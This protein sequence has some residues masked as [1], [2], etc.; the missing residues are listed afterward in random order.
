MADVTLLNLNFPAN[1]RICGLYFEKFGRKHST[2]NIRVEE[3]LRFKDAAHVRNHLNYLFRCDKAQRWTNHSSKGN[4][5]IYFESN[6]NKGKIIFFDKTL[7]ELS[8]YAK[9]LRE[10]INKEKDFLKRGRM[11]RIELMDEAKRFNEANV[12]FGK[13][14]YEAMVV[15]DKISPI[16]VVGHQDQED[17]YLHW[18]LVYA[19]DSDQDFGQ[20]LA[21]GNR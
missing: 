11:L 2:M 5:A 13:Q 6:I 19:N 12:E 7:N 21:N 3:E 20:V 4:F 18:H 10:R 1:L 8:G 15:A 9:F 14:L 17:Y 16:C